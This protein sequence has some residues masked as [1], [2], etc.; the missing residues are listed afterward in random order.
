MTSPHKEAFIDLLK[1][2]VS[3]WRKVWQVRHEL[4]PLKR[5]QEECD[6]L[7][8]HLA[9]TEKPLSPVPKWIA[10]LIM[11]FALLALAWSW[12]EQLDIVVMAQGKTEPNGQSK[13]IQPL[14]TAEVKKIF[15]QDGQKVKKGEVL[16]EL[17]AIGSDADVFQAKTALQ[18]ARIAVLRSQ[19][20]LVALDH[21]QPPQL[22]SDFALSER[23]SSEAQNLVNQQYQTWLAQDEQ[24][25]ARIRQN[26]AELRMLGEEIEKLKTLGEIERQRTKDLAALVKQKFIANHAYLEQKS[27][28]VANE[29]DLKSRQSQLAQVQ[30]TLEETEESRR[31]NTQTLRRDT[32]ETLRQ[33][34]EE[35][36]NLTAQLEKATQRQSLMQMKAPVN[37]T[38]QQLAVHTV[39]GVATAAQPLMVI[40]PD[41]Y[42]L[43]VKV[44]VL[45]KDIGFL[46]IGQDAVIK[47]EAFP[48]T[49]YGYLTGKLTNISYDAIENEHLGLVYDATVQLDKET[50]NIEG[51]PVR[52]GAGMNVTVEIKTGKRRVI[53]YL[54]SPLQTK[55]DESMKQR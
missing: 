38:V 31:V 54:L 5:E 10:R 20:L 36:P 45:N 1:R 29:R 9:L 7:P 30:A 23:E 3:T 33:A 24:L 51:H 34:N 46:R 8:A 35:I 17:T 52:L 27:K 4:E 25:K 55:I 11:L 2:Y 22:K 47:I 12:F 32:L 15:V 48:Y 18:A 41:D 50:L 13:V 6:F 43:A 39:G 44:M 53:D 42:Q 26:K 37:G 14:E 21:S 49:R 16:I 28:L 19:A 40:V